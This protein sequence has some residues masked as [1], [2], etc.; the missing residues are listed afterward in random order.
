MKLKV[1][2]VDCGAVIAFPEKQ[3]PKGKDN[4]SCPACGSVMI[5]D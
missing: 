3:I 4:P 2:C 5:P 1:R